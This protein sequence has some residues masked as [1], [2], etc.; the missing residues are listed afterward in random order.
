VTAH[1]FCTFCDLDID[2]LDIL[3]PAEW[4][5]KNTD[6]IRYVAHMYKDAPSESK[7]HELFQAYGLRW[8]SLLDLPYWN[9]VLYAIIDSMHALDLGLFQHHCR[10]LFQ[11]DITVPGGDGFMEPPSV[12][13]KRSSDIGSLIDC[14]QCIRR[15]EVD[16]LGQLVKYHRRVLYTICVNN[17]IQEPGKTIVTGTKW[18]LARSIYNWVRPSLVICSI[19]TQFLLSAQKCQ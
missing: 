9:P 2:D 3:D 6:H 10:K 18:V 12:K 7:Q 1:Y 11:I 15:N 14:T 19:F 13:D 8:S 16:M 17:D 4:P 5:A